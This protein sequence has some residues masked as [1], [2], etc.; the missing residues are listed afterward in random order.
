M[1]ERV[2]VTA[3]MLRL[4]A[5]QL[6]K[7][8]YVPDFA[9]ILISE[10]NNEIMHTHSVLENPSLVLMGIGMTERAIYEEIDPYE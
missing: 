10:D 5:D 4:L 3:K 1:S 2:N 7:N 6:D 8:I 9:F